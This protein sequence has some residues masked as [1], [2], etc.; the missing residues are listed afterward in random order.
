MTLQQPAIGKVLKLEGW[1]ISN[2]T[3]SVM[4]FFVVRE[5]VLIMG[6]IMRWVLK[7]DEDELIIRKRKVSSHMPVNRMVEEV[8]HYQFD[9][10]DMGDYLYLY[11]FYP[12]EVDTVKSA[13]L[14]GRFEKTEASMQASDMSVDDLKN[15]DVFY[16]KFFTPKVLN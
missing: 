11:T 14:V 16:K 13:V 8:G 12:E 10:I 2:T 4:G 15:L 1:D 3:P 9:F 7:I 5:E 6:Y